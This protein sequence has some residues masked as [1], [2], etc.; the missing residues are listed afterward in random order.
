[1]GEHDE[2]IADARDQT[3]LGDFGDDSFREGLEVLVRSL[4]GEA[5][6]N[7]MGQ[8]AMRGRL[9]SLLAQRL[10]IEDWYR[11]HPE[12]GDEPIEAPLIGLGL[13]RTG[14]TALSF[15][16]AEDPGARSLRLW[17][18]SAPA[19]PPSTVDGARSPDRDRRAAGGAAEAVLAAQRGAR[20]VDRHRTDGVPGADGA[21]LQVADLPGLRVPPV[22]LRLVL[23]DADLTSTYEYERRVL[24]LLQWGAPAAAV[25]AE[26]PDAPALPRRARPVV[27]RRAVR[28]DPSRP[29][30]RDRLGRRRLRGDRRHV[31]RRDR[32]ALPGRAQ[33]RALVGG[34]GP[35]AGVP[36]PR[37]RPPVLRHRLPRHA[38]ATR[39]ARSPGCTRGWASRS[40]PEFEAG[41]ATWWAEN[42]EH[43]EP[44]VH[45]D[46]ATFGLDLDDVRPRFA[47][48]TRRSAQW[49][50]H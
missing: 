16:L 26:V 50:A 27:P 14:S 35:G 31:Q 8:E 10:Q 44:N 18:S 42:A 40:P 15:L 13:P 22:V 24:K 37:Q 45:P 5:K 12:I 25:A 33:R 48:Y 39:S 41:M 43:R 4:Q 2:L 28:D 21:R 23:L 29:D 49:T 47:E 46:P 32:P 30:R 20:A 3:G 7:A 1:M 19:P 11:R 17:E 38:G 6:L 36:R 9:V 34:D